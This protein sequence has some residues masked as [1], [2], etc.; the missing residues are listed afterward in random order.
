MSQKIDLVDQ[1]IKYEAGEMEEE[2]FIS[3]FQY[4][5]DTGRAWTLQGHYGRTAQHLID[6]GL[7]NYG[8]GADMEGEL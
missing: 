5:V 1:I 4:L 8:A 2:E 3:F 6:Q 7:V